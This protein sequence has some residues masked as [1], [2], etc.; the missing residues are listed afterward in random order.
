M[1]ANMIMRIAF[2]FNFKIQIG[3]SKLIVLEKFKA[4]LKWCW[5]LGHL[6]IYFTSSR[7]IF[8]IFHFMTN[9]ICIIYFIKN[10]ILHISFNKEQY[11][12]HFYREKYSPYFILSGTIFSI[13]YVMKNNNIILNILI[14]RNNIF[15]SLLYQEQLS[16][17]SF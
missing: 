10:D 1:I 7:T 8:F 17:C 3:S 13:F 15:Y 6:F 4:I 16:P 2:K 12:L 5:I 14:I 9:N 11:F